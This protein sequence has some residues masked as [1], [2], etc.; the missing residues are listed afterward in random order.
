MSTYLIRQK[1]KEIKSGFYGTQMI[2]SLFFK[3]K[4]NKLNFF[5][6]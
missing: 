3:N 1:E 4:G 6:R 5:K 2:P